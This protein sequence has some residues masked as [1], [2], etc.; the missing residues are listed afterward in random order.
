MEVS[1]ADQSG[2]GFAH[3]STSLTLRAFMA[4][5][6]YGALVTGAGVCPYM[7]TEHGLRVFS[8][9]LRVLVM[10]YATVLRFARRTRGAQAGS[11]G[12]LCSTRRLWYG[13][14]L[15]ITG[16]RAA[17]VVSFFQW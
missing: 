2:C 1:L 16:R 8:L 9:S 17:L 7:R 6:F 13:G 15:S 4:H 10:R 5:R 12:L 3:A 14:G 11:G